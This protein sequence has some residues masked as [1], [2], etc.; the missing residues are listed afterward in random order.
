MASFNKVILIGNLT[1]DVELKYTATGTAIGKVSLATNRRWK[2][3]SGEAK[4]ETTFVDITLFGKTAET[5]AK[6]TKKG[7]QLMVEGRL[8]L[9]Q[10]E[11][12][13]QKFSKLAVIGEGI[14][15]LGSAP[16]AEGSAPAAQPARSTSPATAPATSPAEDSE[17]PF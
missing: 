14:Q 2:T 11:K 17:I 9:E 3:E 12:E 1:R 5:A 15:L 4:E 8:N 6:Y 16:K 10:W 7:N 13:G